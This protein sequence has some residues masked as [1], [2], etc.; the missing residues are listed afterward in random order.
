MHDAR[1]VR[2]EGITAYVRY[3]RAGEDSWEDASE[4]NHKQLHALRGYLKDHRCERVFVNNLI[5]FPNLRE[6]DLP[7]RPHNIIG[8]DASFNKIL[9]VLGEISGPWIQGEWASIRAGK[10]ENVERLF[11]TSLFRSITPTAIDR[12]RM[13]R[14]ARRGAIGPDWL[15]DLGQ[16]QVVFRGRGGAGKTVVLLQL[17]YNAFDINGARS[18]LL[19]YNRALMADICRTMALLQIPND[20]DR[21][22]VRVDSVMAFV[23]RVLRYFDLIAPDDNFL[24][25][26]SKNCEALAEMLHEDAISANDVAEIKRQ[27]ATE[28]SFDHVF[29]DEGQDWPESEIA[30]LRAIYQPERLIIADGIDQFVRGSVADWHRGIEGERLRTRRLRRCLRMKSNLAAFANTLAREIEREGWE[31]EPNP[32]AAGGRVVIVEGEYF[33]DWSIHE[34]IIREARAVGNKPV[35]LVVCVPPTLAQQPDHSAS[36]LIGESVARQAG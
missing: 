13:D 32:D 25:S 1:A 10:S 11:R 7:K 28:F 33:R 8:G 14:I 35:D 29:I 24:Q 12:K 15:A 16:R 34:R 4:Q 30:I 23:G 27:D 20:I 5:L 2:F 9:N 19:T 36:S 17:A 3:R 31:V 18:L 6:V 22:G 21:G 26:Y